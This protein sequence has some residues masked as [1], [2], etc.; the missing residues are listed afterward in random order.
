MGSNL[1]KNPGFESGKFNKVDQWGSMTVPDGW[2][3]F[4]VNN[5]G[6]KRVPWDPKNETG[7]VAPEFKPVDK[8]PPYL[9]PPRGRWSAGGQWA[10]CWFAFWKV[11][12]AGLMQHVSVTPG[13][14][15]R[16]TAW[17][18]GWS[19][20]GNRDDPVSGQYAHDP[21]WS[22]GQGVGYNDFFQLAD[23]AWPNRGN[24]PLDDAARNMVFQLGIDPTGGKDPWA[25]SVVWGPGAHI[26]NV[27]HPVP[28]VEAVAARNT[29]TVLLRAKNLWGLMHVDVYWDDAD[30]QLVIPPAVLVVQPAVTHYGGSKVRVERN[31]EAE[32]VEALP[33]GARVTVLEGPVTDRD[34]SWVRVRTAAGNEGWSRVASRNGEVYLAPAR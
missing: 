26:Y 31:I 12:D 4:F 32:Y 8:K 18:H 1:L 29:V 34:E 6:R 13:Q 15:Y 25:S 21:K 24:S 5:P 9:D 19:N 20:S 14:T 17:A 11:M 10:E 7:I 33:S 2:Q 27:F 3:A 30:V 22:D 16:L 23:P 28:P